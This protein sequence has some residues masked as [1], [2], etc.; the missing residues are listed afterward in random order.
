MPTDAN[1]QGVRKHG[2][3]LAEAFAEAGIAHLRTPRTLGAV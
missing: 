2:D 3:K 1:A